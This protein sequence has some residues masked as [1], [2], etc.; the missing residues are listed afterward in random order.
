MTGTGKTTL[1]DSMINYLMGI[2]FYDKFRYK[3]I[4]ETL[5]Q[6]KG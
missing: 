1:I 4:D 2:E 3:L 6:S 5:Q